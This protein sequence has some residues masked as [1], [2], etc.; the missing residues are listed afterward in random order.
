MNG[1][2]GVAEKVHR[3][4]KAVWSR[5]IY[6]CHNANEYKR[7]GYCKLDAKK[8]GMKLETGFGGE[9]GQ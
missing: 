4:R 5:R 2:K 8:L 1:L 6:L 7:T 9:K 3:G